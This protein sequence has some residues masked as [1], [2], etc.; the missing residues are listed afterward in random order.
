MRYNPFMVGTPGELAD[1]LMSLTDWSEEHYKLSSQRFLQ[2]LFRVLEQKQITPDLPTIVKYFDKQILIDLLND[3]DSPSGQVLDAKDYDIFSPVAP[4]S[5]EEENDLLEA[6]NFIDEAAIK[7]FKGRLGI[8]AEGDHRELLKNKGKVLELSLALDEK[9]IVLFSLDSLRY[10][11]QARLFGKLVI[12]DIKSQVTTHRTKRA[13][14]WANLLFD[15]FNVF[16]SSNVMDLVTKSRSAGFCI[17]LAM[18]GF[19]DIDRLPGG[20]ALRRQ[21]IQNC[22]T[23]IIQRI[24]DPQDAEELAAL[25]G[26]Q[27][28]YLFTYQVDELGATDLG[29][30]RPEQEFIIH[31]NDIKGLKLGEAFVKYHDPRRRLKSAHVWVNNVFEEK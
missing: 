21:I 5:N 1:K 9:A 22:N 12:S 26:T 11:E 18:Q 25:F 19:S 6:L 29:S 27:Q 4:A 20:E 23:I 8:L 3:G 17:V 10:P 13:G 30:M 15:E 14:E 28:T 7:G 31:P 24:N 16:V 2:L